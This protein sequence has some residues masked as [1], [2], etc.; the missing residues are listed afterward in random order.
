MF[1]LMGTL[2][3]NRQLRRLTLLFIVAAILQGLTLGLMIPFLRALF[4]DRTALWPWTIAIVVAGVTTVVVNVAVLI[5]SYRVSVYEICDA[6]IRRVGDRVMQ[7]P[8]GWF[9]ARREAAVAAAVA[10]EVG[11]LSHVASMLL[12][13]IANGFVVPATM[14]VV[15]A[16]VDWR[17]ALIMAAVA[18]F[19]AW[20]WRRMR[21]ITVRTKTV[22]GAVARASAGRL[23][24]F[25]R[26]QPVL[27]ATRATERGW[28]PLDAALAD[29]GERIEQSLRASSRPTVVFSILANLMMAAV[30]AV[31]LALALGARLDMAAF[32]AVAAVTVRMAEP[33]AQ[34]VLYGAEVHHSVV[35]LEAI[36]GIVG[37]DTLPEP[38]EDAVTVPEDTTVGFEG[39]GFEYL[40]GRPVLDGID[41]VAPAGRVTAIIGPSGS[42]KS[43]LLRLVGRFWDVGRG[44]VTIGGVD[45]RRIPTPVLMDHI[46]MVFQDVYLFD[47]T[48]RENLR[49]ARPDATDE[50]LAAAAQAA[51]LD[52][53]IDALPDG[54]DT[55]VGPAGSR[56][57]GGE[58]QR[59]AIARAFVKDAP[60]LLL[61][62][63]TSALDGENEA[64][65][66]GVI[67][68]LAHGRTVIVV[69]HRLSTVENADQ[70]VVLEPG[71]NGATIAEHGTPTD[72][73][74]QGGLY[75]DFLTASAQ[76]GRWRL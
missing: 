70:I 36:G 7:L 2:V 55:I 67:S 42:G 56:L 3:G 43:T 26:L 52:R 32:I 54:W 14:V 58:R 9:D 61:D 46:A 6:L 4:G 15:V 17:L 22:E 71:E 35:A 25:A 19:L 8:L 63:V 18:P 74:R 50:Q 33:L 16:F 72:L 75:A 21:T 66:T 29:E 24:E 64:A 23:I 65:I 38:G 40:S 1:R 76:R 53:V 45:V 11:T 68:K 69:A 60:I 37:A 31:G 47:T 57:S 20:A 28:A 41:L 34:A 44:R 48:I 59:V 51:S 30:L 39:V 13:N 27:R 12:P 73:A 10:N 49:L 5:R 62:E